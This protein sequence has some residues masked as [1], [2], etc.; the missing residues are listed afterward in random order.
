MAGILKLEKG[1]IF[2]D[3]SDFLAWIPE[4][5]GTSGC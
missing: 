5:A 1:M 2:E 3:I 4:D